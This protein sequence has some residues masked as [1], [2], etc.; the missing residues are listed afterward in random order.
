MAMK[1]FL[2]L[3]F[4]L[5]T[6]VTI[7]ERLPSLKPLASPTTIAE[8]ILDAPNKSP[9]QRFVKKPVAKS[10]GASK[11]QRPAVRTSVPQ[12]STTAPTSV[13]PTRVTV[14]E[15]PAPVIPQQISATFSLAKLMQGLDDYHA[16]AVLNLAKVDAEPDNTPEN[17]LDAAYFYAL[18]DKKAQAATIAAHF[19]QHYPQHARLPEALYYVATLAERPANGHALQQLKIQFET[20][21]WTRAAAY[22]TIWNYAQ[23]HPLKSLFKDTR[24][25]D[26]QSRQKTLPELEKSIFMTTIL[27]VFPGA[28]YAHL[29]AY[30]LALLTF[31]GMALLAWALMFALFWGQPPYAA[32]WLALLVGIYG[33]SF[34]HGRQLTAEHVAEARSAAFASWDDLHPA[35]I[36]ELR[37]Q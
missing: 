5:L 3:F 34:I 28:G 9:T 6:T 27:S 13:T 26:L 24:A 33:Y 22:K 35:A 32:I 20:S 11:P 10:V 36:D 31:L 37:A 4:T 25:S 21:H 14:I 15:A 19:V 16:L 23:H 30:G 18:A 17:L 1:L 7:A 8:T 29:G 2:T 12:V